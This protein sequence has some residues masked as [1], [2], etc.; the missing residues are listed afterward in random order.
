M[1]RLKNRY[2][3]LKGGQGISGL[4][5][6]GMPS[7]NMPFDTSMDS[8]GETVDIEVEYRRLFYENESLIHRARKYIDELPDRIG[9]ILELRYINNLD[10]QEVANCLGTTEEIIIREIERHWMYCVK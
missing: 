3:E 4:D 1:N 5:M 7:G 10:E 8:V 2:A 9:I 6:S